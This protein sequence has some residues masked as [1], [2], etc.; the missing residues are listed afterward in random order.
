MLDIVISGGTAVLPSGPEPADIGV[1]GEHIA[2]IGAPGSLAGIGARRTVDAA[3]QIVIP[4]G[5]DPH[6]H[7]NW[8]MPMPGVSQPTLTEPASR[9]SLAA[10]HGG[11]TTTIDF[12]P[13]E[14]GETIQQAIERRHKQWAGAC[15][16]DYAFHTMLLGKIAP[17]RL[18]ELAEAVQAGHA[19]VK[20]FTTDITPSRR[21]RMV[22]FGDIWEVLKVLAQAGGIAAIHAEDN[23]IVMHMYEK[24]TREDRT[25]FENMAEVHNTLSEDLS[26][27]RVIRL[28][29]NIE[30][31]A[32]YMMHTSAKT[33]VDAIAAARTRGVP[34]YGET[35]H[36]YLMYTAEDYR[37]PNGQIY[38]TYP[39]LKF[40]ED[41]EALWAATDHGAIQTVATDEICCPLRIKLQGRRIDDTTGGN[42][43]VEPRLS[44]IYTETVEKRG[45]GLS[46]FVGLVS[47][48]AA[49]I[50]G[51][52]PR[53]GALAVGSDADIVL[54]DPRQRKIVRAAELHE[55]DYTPWE[56]RDL[57]AWP[58]LVMLRGKI[59]VE[60]GAFKGDLKHGQF[61]SRKVPEEI[62]TRPVV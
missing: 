21:G 1:S 53:K 6:V 18:G 34:I 30:G 11:T 14:G 44:L 23:D 27:N 25:G 3:G 31:A 5:I 36:Q 28:A 12:A 54:L 57:A 61:L 29:A 8:P 52:Y 60:G 19:S 26:F 40:R 9:V 50:M 33:G 38:H 4:G 10:L 39:S 56:G 37:R 51:L 43:G 15:Y 22:D 2:A 49:K 32:L 48:N 20:M 58:S 47:A 35:L 59:V 16:G 7:C 62:R 41:Q 13:V 45:Y 24:L 17:E 46:D 55:A 42:A